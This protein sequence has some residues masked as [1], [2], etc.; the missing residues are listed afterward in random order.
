MTQTKG[1]KTAGESCQ[2]STMQTKKIFMPQFPSGGGQ[3]K[4]SDMRPFGIWCSSS[5]TK[6]ICLTGECAHCCL[7]VSPKGCRL[8]VQSV[9]SCCCVA[10]LG[11]HWAAF[12]LPQPFPEWLGRHNSSI[13]T[14]WGDA[15]ARRGSTTLVA[16]SL[17]LCSQPKCL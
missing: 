11:Q 10:P 3:E 17:R 4:R 8:T 16:A 1:P 9:P 7:N 12:V 6:D 2:H 5:L 15:T 13:Q 14:Q